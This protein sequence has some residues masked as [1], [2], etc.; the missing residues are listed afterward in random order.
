MKRGAVLINV[1]RGPVVDEKALAEALRSGQLGGVGLDVFDP[2][3]PGKDHP[4][5]SLPNVVLTPHIAGASWESKRGC[6]MVV[7]DIVRILR[8]EAPAHPVA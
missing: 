6:S 7:V 2:E 8:G 4:L 3:P 1:S 5:Y